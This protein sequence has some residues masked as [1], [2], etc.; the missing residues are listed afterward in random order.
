MTQPKTP[1]V[2]Q[3]SHPLYL[4]FFCSDSRDS[5]FWLFFLLYLQALQTDTQL[6]FLG[7]VTYFQTASSLHFPFLF[8]LSLLISSLKDFLQTERDQGKHQQLQRGNQ[9][10]FSLTLL[11]QG[12]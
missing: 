6:L 12:L 10:F 4:G 8:G 2:F 7:T 1:P 9:K 3:I 11:L 5:L